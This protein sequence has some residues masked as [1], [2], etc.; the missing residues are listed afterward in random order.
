ML[1]HVSLE[2]DDPRHVAH[3]FA[4]I[5]G[6]AAAPFPPVG[7]DSWVALA[8]DDR[9]TMIEIYPRGTEMHLAPDD[10]D[11]IG[12]AA[13]PRRN[14]ATHIAIAT[15]C[16]METIFQLAKREGWP[17]KYCRRGGKFGVIELWVEGCLLVEVL[18]DE[19]QREYLDA[20]TI[21]NWD[22]MI[23]EAQ[24]KQLAETA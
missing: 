10:A 11:A 6:G 20:V 5:L 12:I 8:G 16:D 1:F 21:P 7:V 18:T 23:R 4:E 13:A 22:R 17:A 24:A 2:A 14:S 19:M 3:V 15:H 9:G